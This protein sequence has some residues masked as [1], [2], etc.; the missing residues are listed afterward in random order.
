MS[1]WVQRFFA[2]TY[3]FGRF[4]FPRYVLTDVIAN[5]A[6][7][8]GSDIDIFVTNVAGEDGFGRFLSYTALLGIAALDLVLD[9]DRVAM[10]WG[11]IT[12][13]PYDA[14]NATAAKLRISPVPV[15]GG[16][17]MNLEVTW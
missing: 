8:K 2:L 11:I 6:G 1:P 5:L 14:S 15:A 13:T 10:H 17:G 3:T 4:D 12:G 9:W 7:A 16:L